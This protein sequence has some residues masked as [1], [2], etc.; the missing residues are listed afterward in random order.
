MGW[1]EHGVRAGLGLERDH[2]RGMEGLVPM[3]LGQSRFSLGRPQTL[4]PPMDQ[5]AFP[6]NLM[7]APPPPTQPPVPAAVPA[8]R[9]SEMGDAA[10]ELKVPFCHWLSK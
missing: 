8:L 6:T 5:W 9:W 2:G 1:A 10:F 3:A 7:R 4:A